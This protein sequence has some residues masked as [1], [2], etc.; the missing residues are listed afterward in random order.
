MYYW[1]ERMAML[2]FNHPP[3]HTRPHTHTH[4]HTAMAWTL[5]NLALHPEHQAKCRDEV[6]AIFDEKDEIG[7]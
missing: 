1:L 6:D 4:A 3:T 2:W 5:Y 7:M